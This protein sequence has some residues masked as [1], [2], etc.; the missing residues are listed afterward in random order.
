MLSNLATLAG[1]LTGGL[2]Q[3]DAMN[4]GIRQYKNTVNTAN[5]DIMSQ[6]DE[7][8]QAFNPYTNSGANASSQQMNMINQAQATQPTLQTTTAGGVSDWLDP[9]M[10]YTQDQAR[11]QAVAAGAAS[12]A[13]GGGMM[14][15]LS[16]NANKMA[17][18]NWNNAANQQLNANNQNFGQQQQQY[19]NTANFQ[20]DRINQLGGVA[21][22][23][24]SAAG[25]KQQLGQG[26]TNMYNNN[27]NNL[28]DSLYNNR[29]NQGAVQGNM[30]STAGSGVSSLYGD[31]A[32]LFGGK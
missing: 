11:K 14:K 1:N 21:Q 20:N 31:F 19:T 6:R 18:T 8:N 15:A 12:G 10:D 9:S 17:M 2:I 16:D 4:K 5:S 22:T 32:K 27:M 24:L 13:M 26:Y 23:G 7:S 29:V 3:N 28:A 25:T 30:A